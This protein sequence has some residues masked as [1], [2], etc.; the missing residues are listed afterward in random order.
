MDH[1]KVLNHPIASDDDYD[2][3]VKQLIDLEQQNP[4]LIDPTSPTREFLV[5][6]LRDLRRYS[7]NV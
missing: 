1:A 6:S 5:L 4:A 7:I 2:L 3:A